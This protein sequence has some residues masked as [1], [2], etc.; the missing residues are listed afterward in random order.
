MNCLVIKKE[1]LA[2]AKTK[3]LLAG[4]PLVS[5]RSAQTLEWHAAGDLWGSE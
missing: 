1:Q 3:Q 5:L 2:G 4:V